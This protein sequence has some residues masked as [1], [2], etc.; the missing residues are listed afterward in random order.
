MPVVFLFPYVYSAVVVPM[1]SLTVTPTLEVILALV[2][3]INAVAGVGC[4]V[5][6][7]TK[8][9]KPEQKAAN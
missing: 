9:T 1:L 6:L 2:S 8:E 4:I 5:L 7:L 3:L